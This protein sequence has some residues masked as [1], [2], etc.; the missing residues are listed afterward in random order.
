MDIKMRSEIISASAHPI[1]D[2]KTVN[3]IV[4]IITGDEEDIQT[5]TLAGFIEKG[6]IPLLPDD[7]VP[8]TEYLNHNIT[9]G[10]LDTLIRESLSKAEKD[11]YYPDY[12]IIN[13]KLEMTIGKVEV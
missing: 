13:D 9:F 12:E 5:A 2:V 8:W 6:T 11:D 7:G 3:G 1:W 4:P 10:E